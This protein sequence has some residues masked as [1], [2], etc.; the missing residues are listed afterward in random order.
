MAD[1]VVLGI[2]LSIDCADPNW[3]DLGASIDAAA[4]AGVEFVELP[5][6]SSP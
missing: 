4:A 1:P 5:L 6:H 2:G 3:R